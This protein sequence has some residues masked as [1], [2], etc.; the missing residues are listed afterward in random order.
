MEGDFRV[1]APELELGNH[2]GEGSG[3]GVGGCDNAAE[4]VELGVDD[5]VLARAGDAGAEVDVS[6]W[7]DAGERRIVRFIVEP[8]DEMA[9]CVIIHL[10]TSRGTIDTAF[11]EA[12][13]IRVLG[14]EQFTVLRAPL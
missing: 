11:Y 1:V 13:A 8:R 4:T 3:E 12:D 14:C 7:G 5:V 6:A 2:F 10:P 9:V